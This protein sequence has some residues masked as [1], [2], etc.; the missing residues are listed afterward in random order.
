[1]ARPIT[2]DDPFDLQKVEGLEPVLVLAQIT[3]EP[4]RTLLWVRTA[5]LFH[6]SDVEEDHRRPSCCTPNPALLDQCP[7]MLTNCRPRVRGRQITS[8]E[9]TVVRVQHGRNVPHPVLD[10]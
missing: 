5:V 9:R 6:P 2:S 7:K 4:L 3:V 8:D 10:R 1:M